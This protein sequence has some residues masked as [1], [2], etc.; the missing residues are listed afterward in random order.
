MES[1]AVSWQTGVRIELNCGTSA[2]IGQLL[3][4][5]GGG[6]ENLHVGICPRIIDGNMS[7]D[8]PMWVL[9]GL[10]CYSKD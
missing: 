9:S 5:L 3:G 6:G 1:N 2:S 8:T 10:F 4:S 7:K